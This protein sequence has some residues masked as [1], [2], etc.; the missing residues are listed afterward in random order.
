MW[1]C[2]CPDCLGKG[3]MQ[4]APQ[5]PLLGTQRAVLLLVLH[6]ACQRCAAA[7][8]P[9]AQQTAATVQQLPS[10]P[11]PAAVEGAPGE[12]TLGPAAHCPAGQCL[13]LGLQHMQG[14]TSSAA[15]QGGGLEAVLPAFGAGHNH[16]N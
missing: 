13:H 11:P 4:H 10:L 5:A 8:Q 9:A 16:H 1:P 3:R 7:P 2:P 6:S 14:A 12:K 15:S